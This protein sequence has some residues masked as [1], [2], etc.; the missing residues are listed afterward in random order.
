MAAKR[1]TSAPPATEVMPG[2][3]ALIKVELI[4]MPRI[5]VSARHSLR[6]LRRPGDSLQVRVYG[7]D[8]WRYRTIVRPDIARVEVIQRDGVTP[9]ALR[10]C[11]VR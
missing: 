3:S 10:N 11:R 1:Q 2:H 5:I 7:T 6:I 8:R 4:V 9:N